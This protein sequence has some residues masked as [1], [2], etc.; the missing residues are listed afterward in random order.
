MGG[1]DQ[2][3]EHHRLWRGEGLLL[4]MLEWKVLYHLLGCLRLGDE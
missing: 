1:A 4:S 2:H 3:R